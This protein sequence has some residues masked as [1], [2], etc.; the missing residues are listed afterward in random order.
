[1]KELKIKMSDRDTTISTL[2]KSS[3]VQVKQF[4]LLNEEIL[5]LE[6]QLKKEI[7]AYNHDTAV[8]KTQKTINQLNFLISDLQRKNES[9]SAEI[10]ERV[11]ERDSAISALVKSSSTQEK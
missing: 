7:V 10:K 6:E 11:L 3:V 5:K 8:E 4:K 1:M 9:L 2:V